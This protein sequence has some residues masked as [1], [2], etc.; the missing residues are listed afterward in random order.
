M[1]YLLIILL[2][3]PLSCRQNPADFIDVD[4]MKR[5]TRELASD[6][7]MGR[8]PFT[9]GEEITV[10]FLA[11]ELENIGFL[12]AFD[13]S[14][15]QDVP[16]I[17]ITSDVSRDAVINIGG[18][19]ISLSTPDMIAINSPL[20]VDKVEIKNAGLVFCGFGIEAPEYGWNDFKETDLSGKI[21]VVLVNDPGFYTKDETLFRGSE[22]T[23]YGRWTYKFDIAARKGA[24]GVLIV[25]ET[26][27]AGY[28]FNVPRNSSVSPKLFIDSDDI[29][30]NAKL[31]GWLSA[32]SADELFRSCGY[33]TEELTELALSEEFKPIDLNASL[34]VG[35]T[36]T[37]VKNSSKNV[38]GILRGTLNPDE[39]VVITAHWDHFGI[40]EKVDGDSIYNGAVDNATAMA[41]ALETARVL[42]EMR[43]RPQRS[44]VLLFPTAEEQGLLGSYYYVDNPATPIDKVVACINNDMML[45]R[46]VMKDVTMIGF[47]YSTLDDIYKR[48]AKKQK[49]YLLPDPNSHTGLFF[50][51]DHFPFFKAGVPAI[52]AF[53]SFD[54]AENGEQWA[55][56]TWNHFIDNV[57]HT[58]ADNYDSNWNWDGMVLDTELTINV[59]VELSRASTPPPY[60]L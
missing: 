39:A 59:I 14:Y 27:G 43:V 16:L 37:I 9:P 49:R 8:E 46:G 19:S 15:F 25:H 20:P 55:H 33:T 48:Y 35:I 11:K 38:A 60:I 18:K 56:D 23:Y 53:G 4:N 36:N 3:L 29:N 7:F 50:R 2:F 44:V 6:E 21:M 26:K 32:S 1:R 54:S 31:T 58:P 45:P 24:D 34:S 12:P 28:G 5:I 52:W 57:Y 10:E 13:D 47:G 22:M 42:S 40:G 30:N 51:S 17:Q 41:W